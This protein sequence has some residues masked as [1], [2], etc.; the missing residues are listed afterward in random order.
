VSGEPF[1]KVIA[2]IDKLIVL[3]TAVGQ[4]IY[5]R[6]WCCYEFVHAM[7]AL[8]GKTEK[9]EKELTPQ[10][11]ATVK[12]PFKFYMT[13][14]SEYY[15]RVKKALDEL[16]QEAPLFYYQIM[17]FAAPVM[18]SARFKT[19]C[20][21]ND[22]AKDIE[23]DGKMVFAATKEE[24]EDI[25]KLLKPASSKDSKCG[26]TDKEKLDNGIAGFFINETGGKV[27]EGTDAVDYV[28]NTMRRHFFNKILDAATE[29]MSGGIVVEIVFMTDGTGTNMAKALKIEE[30][31]KGEAAKGK[32]ETTTKIMLERVDKF[33][34]VP[35]YF[36]FKKNGK[37]GDNIIKFEE[38]IKKKKKKKKK[39]AEAGSVRD[40][41]RRQR[42]ETKS[43]DI[44]SSKQRLYSNKNNTNRPKIPFRSL[45]EV[46][47]AVHQL[48]DGVQDL[49]D[50]V[51][52]L[53]AI[54]QGGRNNNNVPAYRGNNDYSTRRASHQSDL[55]QPRWV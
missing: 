11:A 53:R 1:S 40:K 23:K 17:H 52:D 3:H 34:I 45:T 30:G 20:E 6:K 27:K 33:G 13:G 39:E 51:S 4:D 29:E 31:L 25:I 54:V 38:E 5:E 44:S 9:Y 12:R 24:F 22:I 26:D 18:S 14:S 55:K 32:R 47:N 7:R 41:G 46:G 8:K 28:L 10:N 48:T 43:I 42:A 35:V 21:E 15:R 49:T 37:V 36:D 19:L 16:K 50:Q 2:A